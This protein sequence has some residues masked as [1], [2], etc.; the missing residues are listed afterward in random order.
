L[1]LILQAVREAQDEKRVNTREEALAL[2]KA[3]IV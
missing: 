3:M 1:G 2:A